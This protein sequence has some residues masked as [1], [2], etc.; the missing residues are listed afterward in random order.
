MSRWKDMAVA[1]R[2]VVWK[3]LEEKEEE[4]SG[5]DY[6]LMILKRFSPK[7]KYVRK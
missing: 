6:C 5:P 7:K 4:F 3:E 1:C 2:G